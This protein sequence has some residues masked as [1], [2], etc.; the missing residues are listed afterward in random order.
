MSTLIE[1]LI[2]TVDVVNYDEASLQPKT[3]T[4]ETF[5]YRYTYDYTT[6]EVKV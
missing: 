4:D 2:G 6:K 5:Y 3:I 1:H